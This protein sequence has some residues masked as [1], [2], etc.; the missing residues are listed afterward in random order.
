[1][2]GDGTNDCGALKAAA[3][4]VAL[5]SEGP[6]SE[7][8]AA[9]R[10]ARQQLP[11]ARGGASAAAK[12]SAAPNSNVTPATAAKLAAAGR[13]EELAA[14]LEASSGRFDDPHAPPIVRL[15]D[16]S[17]A[18]PFTARQASVLPVRDV[19][20]QGRTTLVTTVQMFKILGLNSLINAYALSVQYLDGVKSG[21]NQA[22]MIGVLMAILFMMLSLGR[23]LPKLSTE[24]PH[25]SPFSPYVLLSLLCQF[26][27]HLKLLVDAVAAADK[28]SPPGAPKPD[29]DGKFAPS[30]VNSAS[31]LAVG[32]MQLTTFIVNY[33]GAPLVLRGWGFSRP[34]SHPHR[35]Q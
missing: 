10:G 12:G 14:S 19:I 1:M 24:R 13:L 28:H 33:V 8:A 17:M 6:T 18:A 23:P 16:A 35:M 29:P 30:L 21:D 22:T 3:V 31:F 4:G 26:G 25:A 2:C 9:R 5:V 27:L 11:S 20:R 7:Y 34:L 32:F 15:G